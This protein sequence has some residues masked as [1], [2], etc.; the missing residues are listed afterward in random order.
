[1]VPFF[2]F[3]DLACSSAQKL[4]VRTPSEA[5]EIRKIGSR[6]FAA[7]RCG[8]DL[9]IK[10]LWNKRRSSRGIETNVWHA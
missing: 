10:V 2:A 7:S 4:R 9:T 5:A 1:V 3:S 8:R 6:K